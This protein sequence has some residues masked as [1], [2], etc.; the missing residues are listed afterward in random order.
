MPGRIGS[1]KAL[2]PGKQWFSARTFLPVAIWLGLVAWGD[3]QGPQE[4]STRVEPLAKVN[5]RRALLIG[6]D[7]YKNF[8]KLKYCGADVQALGKRLV[9]A[10]FDADKVV[11]VYDEATRSL[12]PDREKITSQISLILESAEPEDLLL[13]AYSGH[14]VRLHGK[15]YLVPYGGEAPK[16]DKEADV[17]A[18]AGTLI[19]LDWVYEK[20]QA[21]RASTKIFLVD[22]CQNRLFAGD[23]RSTGSRGT[24]DDIGRSLEAAPKGILLLTACAAGEFSH[25]AENFQHGVYTHFLLEALAGKAD[26]NHD[27]AISLKEATLYASSHT[28]RYVREQFHKLQRPS[29]RGE[30]Q[31]DVPLTENLPMTRITVPDDF[32]DLELAL[33]R[34]ATGATILIKPGT[35]RCAQPLVI[36]REVTVQGATGDPKDVILECRGGSVLVLSAPRATLRAVTIRNTTSTNLAGALWKAMGI[37]SS[38]SEVGVRLPAVNITGGKPELVKCDITSAIGPGVVVTGENTGPTLRDCTIHRAKLGG[39]RVAQK[40]SGEFENCEVLAN[41]GAGMIVTGRARPT[42]TR[43]RIRDNDSAGILIDGQSAGAFEECDIWA[44]AKAG[45]QVEDSSN[46]TV[47]NC[48]IHDG[49]SAGILVSEKTL[50]AFVRCNIYANTLSGIEV[51][52]SANPA[53]TRCDVHDGKAAGIHIHAKGF[54]TFDQCDIR[55]NADVGIGVRGES[56]PTFKNCKILDSGSTGV[57]VHEKGFGTFEQ[58]DISANALSGIEV[59]EQG[60]PTFKQCKLR[61]GKQAGISVH[62]TGFGT[63]ED[64]EI[65]DTARCG[66][67]IRDQGNPTLKNCKVHNSGESGVFV[68]NQGFGTFE[69]CEIF[70]NTLSGIEVTAEANPTFR[71]CKIHHGKAAGI[72]AYAKG[73]GTF[74][75]CEIRANTRSGIRVREEANPTM[76]GCKFH[77]E[78]QNGI[79]V[80]DKGFGTFQNCEIRQSARCGIEVTDN[81]NPTVTQCTIGNAQKIGIYV[82]KNG[83]GTF[84][85]NT[86]SGNAMDQWRVTDDAGAVTR[87]GNN[88][89]Q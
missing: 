77:N 33:R 63:F 7:E 52:D 39:I 31:G 32:D 51:S 55:A 17:Q 29:F 44:N 28:E 45:I 19:A 10:G 14:G 80:C 75:D 18:A 11:V 30:L 9:Q 82:H 12:Q 42:V 13:L 83:H 67:H 69:D 43:C 26:Y 78:E 68:K 79:F 57:F 47:K 37:R 59:A 61:E 34:A 81:G 88:P 50:G 35:Y 2:V 40:A 70:A 21:C 3:A 74:E 60:N 86:L 25:E 64:C 49:Q 4:R 66:I 58:C 53:F 8:H 48:K 6:I 65:R 38:P 5:H 1:S 76:K 22:A 15:S 72:Y 24:V 27:G 85:N 54:G 20:L 62:A 46:P 73:F 89:N 41:A 71:R 16:S 84:R 87:E 36:A 56:N 23:V